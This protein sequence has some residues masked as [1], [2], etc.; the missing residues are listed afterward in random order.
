MSRGVFIFV[1]EE[2]RRVLGWMSKMI[3]CEDYCLFSC[4]EVSEAE[5]ST[6]QHD[7]QTKFMSFSVPRVRNKFQGSDVTVC[8]FCWLIFR[9]ELEGGL[10]SLFGFFAAVKNISAVVH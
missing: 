9:F 8:L 7:F 6:T 10:K 2:R 5:R 3:D 4:Q 1:D